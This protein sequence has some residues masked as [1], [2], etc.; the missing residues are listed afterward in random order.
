MQT[1]SRCV[2]GTSRPATQLAC[3]AVLPQKAGRGARN[4][5]SPERVS[6]AMHQFGWQRAWTGP[7]PVVEWRR[8]GTEG[9]A[10]KPAIDGE[11]E[12]FTFETAARS[13][14]G[15]HAVI[16]RYTATSC[17]HKNPAPH[18]PRT[19]IPWNG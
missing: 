12:T 3:H 15:P 11:I 4:C 8:A 17:A 5:T 6:E 19:S 2:I 9:T 7:L 13:A 10:Q 14:T 1:G 18:A 16:S